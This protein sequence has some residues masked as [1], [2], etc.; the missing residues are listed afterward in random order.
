V[1]EEK[2][3][4][5]APLTTTE[6]P[7]SETSVALSILENLDPESQLPSSVFLS[8]I[9]KISHLKNHFQ[10]ERRALIASV[11]VIFKN[12]GLSQIRFFYKKPD[13][14]KYNFGKTIL[15]HS[16]LSFLSPETIFYIEKMITDP[17][18]IVEP[19]QQLLYLPAFIDQK[20]TA[21]IE[22]VR[23]N[24]PPF[25]QTEIQEFLIMTDYFSTFIEKIELN[26]L[27]KTTYIAPK[28]MGLFPAQENALSK[29]AHQA[30]TN[31]E[32]LIRVFVKTF[33]KDLLHF[34]VEIKSLVHAADEFLA[35]VNHYLEDKR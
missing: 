9:Q 18:I 19:G 27:L 34:G 10:N 35:Q 11:N 20:L 24:S 13:G 2:Q 33:F 14:F 1:F 31:Q 8:T 23:E 16:E 6:K 3:S 4:S 32:Q 22:C 28:S 30:L 29:V 26:K 12:Y 5:L 15:N 7:I 21:I 25:T 17:Q